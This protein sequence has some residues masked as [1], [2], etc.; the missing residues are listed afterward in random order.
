VLAD[1]DARI[2]GLPV[3]QGVGVAP[4]AGQWLVGSAGPRARP[5]GT[6]GRP[7]VDLSASSDSPSVPVGTAAVLGIA[8]ALP[9]SVA[10]DVSGIAAGPGGRLTMTVEPADV[11]VGSITVLLGDGSQLA[12]KLTALATMLDQG[13]LAGV[14]EINL[15]VANRPAT[16]TARQTP[17]T[18]STQ[19]GG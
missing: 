14:A 5:P 18:L 8:A 16:L 17:G 11:A 2:P 12:Q 9:P 4:A 6:S 7:Q 3:L 10:A 13:N 15:T 19:L 1:L